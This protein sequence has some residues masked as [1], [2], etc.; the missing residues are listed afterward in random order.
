M[1]EMSCLKEVRIYQVLEVNVNTAKKCGHHDGLWSQVIW[2]VTF[3]F[4]LNI[5][6]F[7]FQ[8]LL[9]NDPHL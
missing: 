6:F 8:S 4:M 7:E 9:R 2:M 5:K 3:N 1:K